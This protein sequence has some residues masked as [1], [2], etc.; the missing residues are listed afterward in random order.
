MPVTPDFPAL[1][2][3]GLDLQ[4]VFDLAALPDDLAAPLLE[5]AGGAGAWRQLILLGHGGRTLWQRVQAAG[6]DSPHPIDDYSRA[7]FVAWMAAELPEATYRLL[8]PGDAPIGLQRLGALAGWHHPSP[9]AVG[10]NERWGTWFAYRLA[11]LA[12][13]ALVPTPPAAWASPCLAC[14]GRP[15][16]AACPAGALDGGI[17]ALAPCLAYRRRGDSPCRETCLARTA[18]PAGAGHRYEAAQLRHTYRRSLAMIEG[19]DISG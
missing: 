10:I 11:A 12:D 6:L 8:Y 3:A 16:I 5:A 2:A 15:C 1:A 17:L 9:L 18:C 19:G 14:D 7:V 4:A 13:T